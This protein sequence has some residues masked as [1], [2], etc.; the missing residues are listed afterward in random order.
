MRTC[1]PTQRLLCLDMFPVHWRSGRRES[2]DSVILLEIT[3]L[4]G[5][6]QTNVAIPTGKRLT[7]ELPN[8]LLSAK[9]SSCKED[10][11]GYLVEILVDSAADWLS[12]SYQ[13]PYVKAKTTRQAVRSTRKRPAAVQG[14]RK[15]VAIGSAWKPAKGG[16]SHR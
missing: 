9:V 8:G 6:L 12:G 3:E 10:D 13:P 15:P 4:G 5:L 2:S 14:R 1:N 7:L 16:R 11:F